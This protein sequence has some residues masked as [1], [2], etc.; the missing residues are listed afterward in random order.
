[1][2]KPTIGNIE[3]L[4][5]YNHDNIQAIEE[6]YH[7][8]IEYIKSKYNYTQIQFPTDSP[9]TITFLEGVKLLKENGLDQDPTADLTTINE[10]ALGNIINDKYHSHLFVLTHYPKSARPFYTRLSDDPIYTNS[11]DMILRGQEICSGSQRENNYTHLTNRMKDLNIDTTPFRD[12]LN[13][14]KYGSPYHGGFGL[15]LERILMLYFDFP[16][17]RTSSLFP[18]DPKRITP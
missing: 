17:I 3:A 5:K 2:N 13:S 8:E 6:K 14:F 16:N 9:L 4:M 10:K 7:N 18:R 1:L 12:Y 15:G 11:F